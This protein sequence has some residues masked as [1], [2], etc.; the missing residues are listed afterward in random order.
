MGRPVTK[1][2]LL[3][4]FENGVG[5][6]DSEM[7][8]ME[9][10]F[11][12]DMTLVPVVLDVVEEPLT[13]VHVCRKAA[14]LLKRSLVGDRAA[15][16]TKWQSLPK[17]QRTSLKNRMLRIVAQSSLSAYQSDRASFAAFLASVACV[18]NPTDRSDFVERM[19]CLL[20]DSDCD[21]VISASFALTHFATALSL[22][23]EAVLHP[24]SL[25][26][27]PLRRDFRASPHKSAAAVELSLY[28]PQLVSA[29]AEQLRSRHDVVQQGCAVHFQQLL[30]IVPGNCH[31]GLAPILSALLDIEME[32]QSDALIYCIAALFRVNAAQLAQGDL[33]NRS[34]AFLCS[35][36]A[37]LSESQLF[38]T[39][40]VQIAVDLSGANPALVVPHVGLLIK[41][42]GDFVSREGRVPLEEIH[43]VIASLA[44]LAENLKEQFLP[45]VIPAIDALLALEQPLI[46][47]HMLWPEDFMTQIFDAVARVMKH[48]AF[49]GIDMIP[50][51][52]KIAMLSAESLST[53]TD[54]ASFTSTSRAM[55]HALNVLNLFEQLQ[56]DEVTETLRLLKSPEGIE[57][58]EDAVGEAARQVVVAFFVGGE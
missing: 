6:D 33:G 11:T 8:F 48:D 44:Q 10:R 55:Q 1:E 45:F 22:G 54:D 23:N 30:A 37:D 3:Q 14:S 47:V 4:L 18:E 24:P 42:I 39:N 34:I 41:A 19:L 57:A 35:I 2:A 32:N 29:I 12:E 13:T 15:V 53:E 58:T 43:L 17:D 40:A 26:L 5:T 50:R 49:P 31:L 27:G 51:A 36:A 52:K 7:G 28:F 25:Y 38:G 21:I 20:R 56:D 16:K 9:K 46:D